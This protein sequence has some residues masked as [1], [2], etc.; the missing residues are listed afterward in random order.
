VSDPVWIEKSVILLLH[1]EALAEHGG[2]EGLRDE[3]LES[4]MARPRNL[5]AYEGIT[6][7]CRLSAAYAVGISRNHPFVDGNKRAAFISLALFLRL[8]GRRLVAEQVEAVRIMLALA[9]GML[10]EGELT[11]WIER[12]V[13]QAT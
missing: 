13:V 10:T 5:L 9:E 3:G 8:N 7:L 11:E 4:A 6:D 2:A 1:A 12:H